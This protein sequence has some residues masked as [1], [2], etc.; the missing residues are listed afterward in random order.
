[1][2]LETINALACCL[3][4]IYGNSSSD[5][6][7]KVTSRLDG[8]VM[9]VTFQTI[10]NFARDSHTHIE[11]QN[12]KKEGAA[13]VNDRV[14]TIKKLFKE[15]TGKALNVQKQ[16]EYDRFETI[17]VSAFSPNRVI[18]YTFNVCYEIK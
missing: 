17:S 12:L 13:I 18:K 3:D 10:A 6:S 15:N 2:E 4:D 9:T 1:M 16:K 7:R 11:S 8:N 5:G 14:K